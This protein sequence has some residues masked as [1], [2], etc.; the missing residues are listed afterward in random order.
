MALFKWDDSL[1]FNIE[2]IDRQHEQLINAITKLEKAMLKG[3]SKTVMG[4]IFNDLTLFLT[5]HFQTEEKLFELITYPEAESHREEHRG[6]IQ[7]VNTFKDEFKDDKIGIAVEI[8]NFMC[9]WVV[10]HI[11]NVDRK[12]ADLIAQQRLVP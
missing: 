10:N 2:I 9:D 3:E 7:K 5:D 11:N 8:M 12:Y 4:D 6:F 1:I